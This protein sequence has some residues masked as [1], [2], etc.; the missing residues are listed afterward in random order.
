MQW[1]TNSTL[2]Y[3][4]DD[5]HFYR[6]KTGDHKNIS[7]LDLKSEVIIKI[8]CSDFLLCDVFGTVQKM[9]VLK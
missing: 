4:S 5:G 7:K 1:I 9:I 6:Y 8:Q 3:G 2:L